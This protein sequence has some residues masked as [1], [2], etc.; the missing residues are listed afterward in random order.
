MFF[1]SYPTAG[2]SCSKKKLELFYFIFKVLKK[3]L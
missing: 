3:V 1:F 2:D